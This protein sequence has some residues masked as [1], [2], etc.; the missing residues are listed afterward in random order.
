[1]QW[2]CAHMHIFAGALA[3]AWANHDLNWQ[4]RRYAEML[5]EVK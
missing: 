1:M 3:D 5:I 4:A 2:L